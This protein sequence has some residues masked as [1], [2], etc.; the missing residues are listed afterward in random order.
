M[1]RLLRRRFVKLADRGTFSV[2]T[3][4]SDNAP[5][6]VLLHGLG[7]SADLNWSAAMPALSRDFFV[8]APDIRGHGETTSPGRFTLED[9]ADDVFE[10]MDALSLDPYTVIGYSMGGAI[11][12][13]MGR[14]HSERLHGLVLCATSDSFRRTWRERVMFAAASPARLAARAMPDQA[15]Q[16]PRRIVARLVDG[17]CPETLE[18]SHLDVG[19]VLEAAVAL[20]A[21]DAHEWISGVDV[22]SAVVVHLHDQLVPAERQFALARALPRATVHPF[23]GDHFGV[24]KRPEVFVS[25]LQAALRSVQRQTCVPTTCAG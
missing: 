7:A 23:E 14:R 17:S 18:P 3:A 2:R 19:R 8:V 6:V 9:A 25:T 12:Q 16:T 5:A 21:F 22:P 1:S 20:G 4:G 10:I 13:V 15:R 24:V 11:A